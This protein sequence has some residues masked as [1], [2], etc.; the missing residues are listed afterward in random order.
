[1]LSE[2]DYPSVIAAARLGEEWAWTAIYRDV[3]PQ[4]L[5]YL[6][7]HGAQEPEDVLGEV[8][9]LVVRRLSTFSGGGR[10]LR[11]WVLTIARN[12][13]IDEWRR[14]ARRPADPSPDDEIAR[15][16]PSGDAERDALE[17]LSDER[18]LRV[19]DTLTRQQ[20]DVVF[21]RVFAGLTIEEVARVVGNTPG[22]VKSLQ[23]RAL[24]AIRREM[25]KEAVSL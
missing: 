10:E 17:R 4:V 22:A 8:F 19:L 6:R 20:R 2:S 18:V 14:D 9:V 11:A 13:M 5:R 15:L 24:A 21:L 16:A 23:N 25:A 12:R 3:S 7:A 1:M